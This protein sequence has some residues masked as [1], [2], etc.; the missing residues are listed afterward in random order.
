MII[1]SARTWS[2][3]DAVRG[4]RNLLLGMMGPTGTGKTF[5]ALRVATGIQRVFGGDIYFVDTESGRALDYA[6]DFKFKHVPF[7]APFSP[8]DYLECLAWVHAQKPGVVI[9]DSM[10]HEHDGPGG[11]LEEKEAEWEKMAGNPARDFSA[12]A[13]PKGKRRRLINAVVQSNGHHI[14]CFRAKNKTTLPERGSG[15]KELVSLG[16][17]PIGGEEFVYEM[18]VNFLFP[19][20]ADGVPTWLNLSPAQESFLKA[21]PKWARDLLANPRQ[22]DEDIGEAMARWAAGGSTSSPA[23]KPSGAG[24]APASPA[25]TT[26][27]APP[28]T[29]AATD[30]KPTQAKLAELQD[31]SG[32][33]LPWVSKQ[34]GRTIKDP[35]KE[36]TAAEVDKMIAYSRGE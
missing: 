8:L 7:S 1:P 32:N 2:A 9:V 13:K 6:S 28:A 33:S 14:F 18:K 3:S 35:A 19:P 29:A 17:M 5:S 12:W 15:Q 24:P 4:V 22:L 27:K 23:T 21:A 36:L 20:L 25:A 16:W 10:S 31:A 11:V 30:S 26:A 34:V